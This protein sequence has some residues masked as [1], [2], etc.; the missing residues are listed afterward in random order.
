M[1]FA[2]IIMEVL[3]AFNY[4]TLSLAKVV[5]NQKYISRT[6]CRICFIHTHYICLCI[7]KVL[8]PC[9]IAYPNYNDFNVF[10]FKASAHNE[11]NF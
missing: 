11:I 8:L 1:K 7:E 10:N 3:S 6:I 9:K 4:F 5:I 2:N